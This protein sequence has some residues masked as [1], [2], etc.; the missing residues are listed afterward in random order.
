[1]SECKKNSS[2][3]RR[4]HTHLL[5]IV[6]AHADTEAANSRTRTRA[7]VDI[8]TRFQ[9]SC[10]PLRP[11]R[12][13]GREFHSDTQVICGRFRV[14]PQTQTEKRETQRMNETKTKN[15]TLPSSYPC[16]SLKFFRFAA[17]GAKKQRSRQSPRS[18][19]QIFAKSKQQTSVFFFFIK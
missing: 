13:F 10:V 7:H 16:V 5:D 9:A 2:G 3:E 11:Q 1:M 18:P 8:L 6:F 17:G 14:V 4:T 19:L 15:A 12:C